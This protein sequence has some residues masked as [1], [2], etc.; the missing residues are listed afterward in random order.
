MSCA[1][2]CFIFPDP[3]ASCLW[4]LEE[5]SLETA[6]TRFARFARFGKTLTTVLSAVETTHKA[7]V[8]HF[9][10]PGAEI[11]SRRRGRNVRGAIVASIP[12]TCRCAE[13]FLPAAWEQ[14]VVQISSW[15]FCV[16]LLFHTVGALTDSLIFTHSRYENMFSSNRFCWSWSCLSQVC[17]GFF[18]GG[19]RFIFLKK[20]C[21]FVRNLLKKWFL[22][23]SRMKVLTQCGQAEIEVTVWLRRHHEAVWL[24]RWDFTGAEQ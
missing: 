15:D 8:V 13:D 10:L 7:A 21:G 19:V 5:R 24:P 14:N 12:N 3:T 22:Y 17:W 9:D 18:L 23:A 2:L 6:P 16:K 11:R 4:H 20:R 1:I